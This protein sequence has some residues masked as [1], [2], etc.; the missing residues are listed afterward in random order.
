MQNFI[1]KYLKVAFAFLLPIVG[2]AVASVAADEL[3][4]YVG[5]RPGRPYTRYAHRPPTSRIQAT[6]N[7]GRAVREARELDEKFHDVLMV[8]FDLKGP[9]A[10]LAHEWL[11]NQMPRPGD[12]LG[13]DNDDETVDITLDSWWVANDQRFDRSDTD[14]AVFVTKGKQK[15]ARALLRMHGLVE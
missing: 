13:R 4:R 3:N 15:E 9:D 8:A 11:H 1:T 6:R 2:K 12:H 10:G 14:S 7:V 5:P